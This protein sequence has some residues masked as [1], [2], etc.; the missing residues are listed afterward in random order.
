[1][2]LI[3]VIV[4][5]YKVEPYL[6]RCIDSI[7]AQSFIDFELILVND[8]SPDNCGRICDEY[9]QKDKRIYVIHK[10]NGGLSSARNAGID[11]VFAS[12]DSQWITFIDSDDL[13]HPQ[14]LEFLYGAVDENTQ[15]SMCDLFKT[16]V[17]TESFYSYKNKCQFKKNQVNEDTLILLMQSGNYLY[18]GACAKLI[19]KDILLK[20]PF[21]IGKIHEDSAVVFKWI[22]EAEFVSITDE[23]LYFYRTNPNS[24]TQVD[25]SLKNLD[26]LWAIEEQI[27][28]YE[29]TDFNEIKK[30]VYRSYAVTC[31]KM[32]HRLSE[33]KDW[34]EEAQKLKKKLKIFI[35]KKGKLIDF[36]ENWHFNMVYGVLYPKPIRILFRLERYI[37][38]LK[39]TEN[40]NKT[41]IVIDE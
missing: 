12:S 21:T 34:A 6:S 32:Y 14:M 25:F 19:K 39:R 11:W 24:I 23:Q 27:N 33:N 17:C 3:S 22:N 18:W 1:M 13:I 2:P 38:K 29:N 20:Y 31:A 30:I 9:A 37:K 10:E 5:V 40:T 28:F 8:G 4:P 26:F 16:S 36:N 15:I 41:N 7:L 35:R